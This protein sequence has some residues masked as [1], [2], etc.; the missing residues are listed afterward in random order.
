MAGSLTHPFLSSLVSTDTPAQSKGGSRSPDPWVRP[1][2]KP[3]ASIKERETP[4][5]AAPQS[6]P[7]LAAPHPHLQLP[8]GPSPP[9]PPDPALDL[10]RAQQETADAIREL[11]GTL[12]QGLAKLSEALSALLPLLPGAPG[13]PQ[14]HHPP[15][16]PP[17]LPAPPRPPLP[18]PPVPKVE[19]NPEPVSLVAA[20]GV[21]VS[22]RVEDAGAR[23]PLAP[24]PAP[25]SPPC[26]RRKGFPTGKRR[27]RWKTP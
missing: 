22:P 16:P 17:H 19:L 7:G 5:P 6:P 21:I 26:K 2:G 4:P 3:S 18:P 10:L 13:V 8:P 25:D 14:P 1:T 15:P 11:A 20:R 24:L 23:P 27:G 9:Q 12:R